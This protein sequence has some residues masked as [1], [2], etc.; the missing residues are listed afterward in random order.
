MSSRTPTGS[1][2]QQVEMILSHLDNLPPLSAVAT[3]ILSLTDDSRA[4]T[5]EIVKLIETDPALTARLLSLLGRAEHGLRREAITVEKAVVLLGFDTVRQVT[6]ALKVLE[7]FGGPAAKNVGEGFDRGEFWKHCL[8]VACAARRIAAVVKTTVRPEEAFVLGLL[9]DMGK[10]ALN[11]TMPRSYVKVLQKAEETRA[12]LCDVERAVLGVDH[13]VVGRRLAERWGLPRSLVESIWLH[14]HPAEAL[15]ASIAAGGHVQIV[16]LADVLVREH[17]IGWSGNRYLPF[18][19]DDL[20][21]A[22][23]LNEAARE[24]II[25]SLAD[26][27]EARA[28]W[29]GVESLT[30]NE[31]CLKALVR[32][33]EE[34]TAAN[35]VLIE[36]NR[37]L[38]RQSR[39]FSAMGRLNR[40]ISPQ[41]AVRE[42]CGVG[43]EVLREA[44]GVSPVVVFVVD[45]SMRWC[46]AGISD[47]T[48][49]SGLFEL[50][51]EREGIATE[52]AMAAQTAQAGAWLLPAGKGL[53]PIVDQF[54]GVL[55]SGPLWIMPVVREREM[56]GAAI[57]PAETDTVVQLR[58]DSAELEAISAAIGLAMVQSQSQAAA[59][60]L[61]DELAEANRR[62]AAMQGE[63]LRSR[64]LQTVVAMAAGAAHELNNP[65]AVISGRAQILRNQSQDANV[66]EALDVI[67]TQA[68][69]CSGIVTDLMDFARPAPP[70]PEPLELR[71]LLE[72]L[73]AELI[74]A[75]AMTGEQIAFEWAPHTPPVRFDRAQLQRV[76]REL[77]DNAIE[78]T[79]RSH[80]RLTIKTSLDLTE[81]DLVVTVA[82][83]GRGMTPD[84]RNR[85]ADPFFSHRPAG[86][87][88]G[89]GL[90]RVQQWMQQ[91]AA[92]M[93]I[94][95]EPGQGTRVELKL[96]VVRPG[97]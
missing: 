29:I 7:V 11:V 71:P 9:H 21:A 61:S 50:S 3:R 43:A 17:R 25:Q 94:E 45:E 23:G 66:R 48:A 90:A 78:A 46:E 65:L 14:H 31:V 32:S 47:G 84:V 80:R 81:E 49:W 27:I 58:G 88:R 39:Y 19:S 74:K 53:E 85:A 95:S 35:A 87:G 2:P 63:V 97:D 59:L 54:R 16:Q 12:D 91:N 72:T 10:D 41:A 69:A 64:T 67:A 57:I 89:L 24:E 26:E 4:S 73:V 40:G 76:F 93:R 13:A 22:A 92:T 18:S 6:L 30:S 1:A 33:A 55:K 8:G 79:D 77:F 51:G 82:D 68:H 38:S 28:A 15:P 52:L 75:D 83:N 44:L 20:A 37:R 34:L 86:R 62:S 5:R 96:P 56:L 36:Q 42:V 70:L 60:S